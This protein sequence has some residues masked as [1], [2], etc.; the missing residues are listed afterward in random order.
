M[1][2]Q[3]RVLASWLSEKISENQE[4]AE[5]IGVSVVIRKTDSLSYEQLHR[6]TTTTE[7]TIDRR[8]IQWQE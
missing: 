4:Y 3:E 6:K 1:S 7:K 5:K 8:K 2:V